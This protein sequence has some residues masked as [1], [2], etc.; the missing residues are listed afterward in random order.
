[1]KKIL[2][3]L[4]FSFG[5]FANNFAMEDGPTPA[6]GWRFLARENEST[7]LRM[8]MPSKDLPYGV[9]KITHR[10]DLPINERRKINDN[11]TILEAKKV[12]NVMQ[13]LEWSENEIQLLFVARFSSVAFYC[14]NVETLDL[15][16]C[17]RFVKSALLY[18]LNRFSTESDGH[19]EL[20]KGE[21]DNLKKIIVSATSLGSEENALCDE[22][23]HKYE[24]IIK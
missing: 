6:G 12:T 18:L 20:G 14:R 17:E 8:R 16:G 13:G 15:T 23:S 11:I 4:V 21:F 24:I 2:I 3:T 22:L 5:L 1:M 19:I 9:S 10:H 7:L